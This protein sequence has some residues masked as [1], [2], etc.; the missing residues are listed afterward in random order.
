MLAIRS[1]L[2][3]MCRGILVP[4][5]RMVTPAA[6]TATSQ[7]MQLA[8]SKDDVTSAPA[9]LPNRGRHQFLQLSYVCLAGRNLSG[10]IQ[11][12]VWFAG[13]DMIV[14]MFEIVVSVQMTHC[15]NRAVER[16]CIGLSLS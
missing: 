7:P 6:T 9:L 11:E 14:E 1:L 15:R 5:V 2:S 4:G 10:V 12:Y 13:L 8:A 16:Q 3:S